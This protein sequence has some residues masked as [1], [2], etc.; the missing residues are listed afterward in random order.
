M[1]RMLKVRPTKIELV[2][3]QRRLALSQRVH[4]ILKDRLAILTTEFI[5]SARRAITARERMAGSVRRAMTAAGVAEGFHGRLQLEPAL[6][7][8]QGGATVKSGTRNL[9]GTRVPQLRLLLP[10][11]RLPPYDLVL[12]SSMVDDAA[13]AGREALSAIIV[14][15]ELDRTLELLGMEIQRTK[16][17]SNALEYVVVPALERT[18]RAL[19]MKFEERDREEKARLKH[20]KVLRSPATAAPS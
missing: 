4:K 17:I 10:E 9:A 13:D 5:A 18:I 6:A 3:L 14:L 16:R 11:R 7:D 12:S 2:K 19:S 20:I 1:A 8:S 15:A